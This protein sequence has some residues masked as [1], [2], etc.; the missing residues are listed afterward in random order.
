MQRFL[1][2]VERVGNK[3]PHPSVIFLLLLALVIVVSHVFYLFG[4]TVAFQVV[5]PETH[6]IVDVT[7]TVNSLITVEGRRF[8]L[9]SVIPNFLGFTALGV[10]IVAMVGV[11]LAEEA[12]LIRTLIRK[13]VNVSAPWAL[14]Y[15]LVFV[16]IVSSIAADSA[17]R[18]R[19]PERRPA[20][21]GRA[22]RGLCRG[23]DSHH[24]VLSLVG[25]T[26]G[27]V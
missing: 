10:V 3:V 7:A 9:T 17:C 27:S 23:A 19:V 21:P 11:G 5:D 15:I 8:M 4:T 22:G 18:G 12:G 16:G 25:K 6:K 1:D 20:S 13:L 14:T 2:V 24:G 26:A